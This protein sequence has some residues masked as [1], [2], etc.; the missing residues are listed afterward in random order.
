MNLLLALFLIV[1]EV[2]PESIKNKTLAGVVEFIYRAVV[3]VIAFVLIGGYACFAPPMSSLLYTLGGY[4]LLRF[5]LFDIIYNAIQGLPIFFIGTT[6]L[7]DK[8]FRWFFIKT[9]LPKEHFLAMLKFISLLI[10]ITWLLR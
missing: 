4:V 5:A 7:Y 3:T 8:W 1:F 6:K 2:V 9:R 10:G